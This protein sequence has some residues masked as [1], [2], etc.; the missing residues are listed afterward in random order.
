MFVT[1]MQLTLASWAY[2]HPWQHKCNRKSQLNIF[3]ETARY[4]FKFLILSRY[5]TNPTN[6]I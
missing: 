2:E 4:K 5:N 6:N 3:I 1:I